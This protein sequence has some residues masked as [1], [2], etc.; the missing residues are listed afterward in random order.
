LPGNA[1][2][3]IRKEI[4]TR[5]VVVYNPK[6][7]SNY[8]YVLLHTLGLLFRILRIVSSP[9][10]KKRNKREASTMSTVLTPVT[11]IDFP[12]YTQD[13]REDLQSTADDFLLSSKEPFD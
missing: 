2:P 11:S 3:S 4:C 9:F 12:V 7:R 13:E 1:S 8:Y 5:Y 6:E 10:L